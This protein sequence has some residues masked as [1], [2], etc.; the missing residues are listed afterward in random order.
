MS[1]TVGYDDV[2]LLMGAVL[3][4]QEQLQECLDKNR[5]LETIIRRLYDRTSYQRQKKAGITVVVPERRRD[6]TAIRNANI[7]ALYDEGM[8]SITQLAKCYKLTPATIKT[9]LRRGR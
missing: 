9:I 3:R 7:I 5:T 8:G 4:Q 6:E 1:V 2:Q